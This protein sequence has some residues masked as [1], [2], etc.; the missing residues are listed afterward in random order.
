MG[1]IGWLVLCVNSTGPR[2]V[3]MVGETLVLVVSVRLFLEEVNL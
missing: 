2:D 3:P 1:M